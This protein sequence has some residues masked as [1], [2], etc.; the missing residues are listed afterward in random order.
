MK[1]VLLVLA[2]FLFVAAFS[3]AAVLPHTEPAIIANYT[4]LKSADFIKL[5]KV[6]DA[7]AVLVKILDTNTGQISTSVRSLDAE[8]IEELKEQ[9]IE[10][11]AQCDSILDD[12]EEA[13]VKNDLSDGYIPEEWE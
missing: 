9:L 1:R 12:M 3:W 6:N 2:L 13:P 11:A 4:K 5:Y 7:Y 10:M 8:N